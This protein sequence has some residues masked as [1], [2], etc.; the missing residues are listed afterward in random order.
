MQLAG[1]EE[2]TGQS[3]ALALFHIQKLHA[4]LNSQLRGETDESR[5]AHFMLAVS[6]I[7]RWLADPDD[8]AP[9]ESLPMPDGS[10]IGM[11]CMH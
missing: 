7:D 1:N 10:P 5:T 2:A 9:V 11:G 3:R 6:E 8:V 4:W